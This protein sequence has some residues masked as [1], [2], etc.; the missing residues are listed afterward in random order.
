MEDHG[1]EDLMGGQLRRLDQLKVA[2]LLIKGIK[3]NFFIFSK[4]KK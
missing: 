2:T 1:F 4:N 3:T